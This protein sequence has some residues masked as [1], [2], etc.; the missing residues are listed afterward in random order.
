MVVT[1]DSR[2]VQPVKLLFVQEAH[3]CAQIDSALPVYGLVGMNR[4]LELL[5]GERTSGG[6]D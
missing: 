1:G 4:L 3:G 2:L 6:D 5:P